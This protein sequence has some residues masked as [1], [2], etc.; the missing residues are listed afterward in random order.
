MTSESGIGASINQSNS[1]HPEGE[2]EG[3]EKKKEEK[4]EKKQ[5]V[6][7]ELPRENA[8]EPEHFTI[9]NAVLPKQKEVYTFYHWDA[10]QLFVA[11]LIFLNFFVEIAEKQMRPSDDSDAHQ[12]FK[13]FEVFFGV[14]FSIELLLNMYGSFWTEFWRSAWNIFDFVIV[15]VSL[16]A[17]G[18]ENL[19]GISVLRLFRAFRVF[20]LFKRV[21]S[22]RQIIE[23]V[24][25]SIPGVANAFVVLL[26]IMGIWSIMGVEFFSARE[27]QQE[28]FGNFPKAMFTMWQVMTMD[29]WASQIGRHV[30]YHPDYQH[31]LAGFYFVSFL[32]ATGIVM[33]NAVI[34]ILL[35]KYL[36]TT[37]SLENELE[38]ERKQ[39]ASL[40]PKLAKQKEKEHKRTKK[41]R[42]LLLT[43]LSEVLTTEVV[44]EFKR[45]DFL[46]LFRILYSHDGARHK[47]VELL[48]R[49]EELEAIK[50]GQKD[51]TKNTT[52]DWGERKI[53]GSVPVSINY[54][55]AVQ[56]VDDE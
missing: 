20:R 34:A 22:L 30:M 50:A 5:W 29:S 11:F 14:A 23:G 42:E 43:K 31:H 4:G 44:Q 7:D 6:D 35:E 41:R 55:N 52:K 46:D 48:K 10:I 16:V 40:I 12:N 3:E 33:M 25:A 21:P 26:L 27:D 47:I 53:S 51:E 49:L 45:A 1:D 13:A 18:V 24:I 19:P 36:S 17:L 38:Q 9:K 15:G 2:I 56:K 8:A 37:E 39:K 32:F 54:A 28:Q